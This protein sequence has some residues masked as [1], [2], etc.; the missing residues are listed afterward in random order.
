MQDHILLR[1]ASPSMTLG[2]AKDV[3][4]GISAL[5]SKVGG[6]VQSFP[7]HIGNDNQVW[8]FSKD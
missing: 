2:I 1:I 3:A 8:V 4:C 6:R 5:P 7:C